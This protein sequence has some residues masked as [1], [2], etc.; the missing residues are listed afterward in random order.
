MLTILFKGSPEETR[1]AAKQITDQEIGYIHQAQQ[2]LEAYL[3]TPPSQQFIARTLDVMAEVF[4][5]QVPSAD[6]LSQWVKFLRDYPEE[7]IRVGARAILRTHKWRS[8]P[9]PADFEHAILGSQFWVDIK[10]EKSMY[11][12]LLKR[13]ERLT[14]K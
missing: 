6:A 7:A 10:T 3:N 4:Q 1:L 14:Q 2:E 9:L 5:A 11:E 13:I 8:L 12:L